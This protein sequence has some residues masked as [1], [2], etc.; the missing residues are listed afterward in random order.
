MA[1][2][3][4][5]SSPE[6]GRGC[7]YRSFDRNERERTL[8]SQPGR[9]G[10]PRKNIN[11]K[12]GAQHFWAEVED[13]RLVCG[14]NGCPLRR[15]HPGLCAIE[16][17][18]R[19]R[20]RSN[21]GA[22]AGAKEV[23]AAHILAPPQIVKNQIVEQQVVQNQIV[24]QV[25]QPPP[26]IDTHPIA[27]VILLL[28]SPPEFINANKVTTFPQVHSEA[29]QIRDLFSSMGPND[30]MLVY[31]TP[32]IEQENIITVEDLVSLSDSDLN[33]MASRFGMPLG[34]RQ[35]FINY[36]NYIKMLQ[37]TNGA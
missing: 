6:G 34:H 19:L 3:A 10:M 36:I 8:L 33:D 7:H 30:M 25:V 17:G 37:R 26:P 14:I 1:G 13:D 27:E 11:L 4:R 2:G 23:N 9:T 22:A 12:S 28:S 29:D 18:R 16:C 35:R 24:Q 31:A 32:T 21:A 20:R 15:R 5:L